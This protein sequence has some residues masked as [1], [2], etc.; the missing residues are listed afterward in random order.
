MSERIKLRHMRRG[1]T[2]RDKLRWLRLWLRNER[3]RL[4]GKPYIVRPTDG[5]VARAE[6]LAREKGWLTDEGFIWDRE[7][8]C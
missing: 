3:R 8:S 2:F 4:R 6:R 1:L 5:D 7:P